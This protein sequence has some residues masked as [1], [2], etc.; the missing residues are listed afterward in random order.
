MSDFRC[1]VDVISASTV[2]CSSDVYS[3]W[4][5]FTRFLQ[6]IYKIN[7]IYKIYKQ[8]FSK[9][10]LNLIQLN[11]SKLCFYK[12]L[13]TLVFIIYLTICMFFISYIKKIWAYGKR[14]RGDLSEHYKQLSWSWTETF[15]SWYYRTWINFCVQ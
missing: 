7:K 4:M 11:Y 15:M 12:M 10:Y 14:V 5:K 2:W 8:Y 3:I 9:F 1:D 13:L 6:K